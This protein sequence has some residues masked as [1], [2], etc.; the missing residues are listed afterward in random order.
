LQASETLY[1]KNVLVLR[2]RFR[3][4]THV[5]LDMHEK[6]KHKFFSDPEVDPANTIVLSE[7]TLSNLF[8]KSTTDAAA[9]DEHDFLD[10]VDILCSLGQTVLISNYHEYFRLLEYLSQFNRGKKIGIV[11]GIYNLA[12]I[13]KDKFYSDLPGG[14]LEAFGQLFGTNVKLYVYPAKAPDGSLLT[15]KNFQLPAS[16]SPLFQYLIANDKFA[17]LTDYDP[18]SL[19]IISDKVLELI[20]NGS[21]EWEAMVPELVVKAIKE[22]CLFDYPCS[23][24]E[25]QKAIERK[26]IADAVKEEPKTAPEKEVKT[27]EKNTKSTRGKSKS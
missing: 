4:V 1:K 10:R 13:F 17:D 6:G 27:P 19:H 16:I 12:D 20:K 23:L 25:K 9:I 14:M 11:L 2:G 18:S 3:P 22:K 24:E 26:K 8:V 21:D 15:C 5:N 7:L